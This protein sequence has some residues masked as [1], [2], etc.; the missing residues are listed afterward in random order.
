M[1]RKTDYRREFTISD[2][3]C[4]ECGRRG[5]SCGRR[6][7]SQREAGHLKK[8]YCMY[9]GKETNHAEV[10]PYGAYNVEDFEE[11]FRLGRFVD[12]QK[13]PIAEL[14]SC[15]KRDCEYNKDGR[16]WNSNHS[17]DCGHRPKEV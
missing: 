14:M 17:F 8:L 13:I 4:T 10:R 5:L 7:G 2:F 12:G 16:C 15:S 9:C 1:G 11:E 6:V 3:F